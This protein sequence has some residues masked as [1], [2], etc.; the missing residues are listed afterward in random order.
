[1]R[2]NKAG[3][4][5][6]DTGDVALQRAITRRQAQNVCC[7]VLGPRTRYH[8]TC[9]EFGRVCGWH[10]THGYPTRPTLKRKSILSQNA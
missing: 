7:S 2:Q 1:M 4:K 10:A 8:L 3:A 9:E 5:V 6:Y